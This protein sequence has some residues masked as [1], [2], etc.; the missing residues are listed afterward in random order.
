LV[1]KRIGGTQALFLFYFGAFGL[2]VSVLTFLGRTQALLRATSALSIA[3]AAACIY[4]GVRFW[5]LIAVA[6]ARIEQTE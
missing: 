1:R 6:P 4:V 3:L 2:V 5:H